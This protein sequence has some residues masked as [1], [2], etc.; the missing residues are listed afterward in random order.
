MNGITTTNTNLEFSFT[1]MI[2]FDTY[3]KPIA[4]VKFS[5]ELLIHFISSQQLLT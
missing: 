2:I 3:Q 5:V 1:F 4:E